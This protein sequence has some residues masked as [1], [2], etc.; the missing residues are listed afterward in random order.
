M[1]Q[2]SCFNLF[3]RSVNAVYTFLLSWGLDTS[4]ANDVPSPIGVGMRAFPLKSFDFL[5][6]MVH[7]DALSYS[8]S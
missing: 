6:K 2:K 4:N 7:S 5:L 1:Y 3:I 8:L